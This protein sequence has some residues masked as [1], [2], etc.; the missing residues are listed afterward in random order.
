MTK[1]M[2]QHNQDFF[3][4]ASDEVIAVSNLVLDYFRQGQPIGLANSSL[5]RPKQNAENH[6]L[7]NEWEFA[8][9]SPA[10]QHSALW[11]ALWKLTKRTPFAPENVSLDNFINQRTVDVLYR[12]C[13]NDADEAHK[14]K[15][16]TE[17]HKS[18]QS[19]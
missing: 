14:S 6:I 19:I 1:G 12:A 3:I 15:N 2:K 17:L 11:P 9:E 10:E 7:G 8:T 5:A 13:L 18:I 16:G 4:M